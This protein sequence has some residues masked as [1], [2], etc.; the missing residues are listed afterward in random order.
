MSRYDRLEAV[1]GVGHPYL[2]E[3]QRMREYVLLVPFERFYEPVSV[4]EA[5]G[6][7]RRTVNLTP[8]MVNAWTRHVFCASRVRM[9]NL[10]D[11]VL[12]ELNAGRLLTA[13]VLMRSH[14]EA[15]AMACLCVHEIRKWTNTGDSASIE[16]LIPPTFF[17]TSMVRA[18]KKT[19]ALE[20]TLLFSEQDKVPIG[21]MISALDEFMSCGKP[22][23]RAHTIYGLLC[24]YTH[25]NMRALKDHTTTDN[26][27]V[28]GWFHRYRVNAELSKN[29]CIMAL[30]AL[31]TSMRAGHA[32]CEMLRRMKTGSDGSRGYLQPP[33]EDDLKEIWETFCRE[34][35]DV[36]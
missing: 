28:E 15:G 1:L 10:E 21:R 16:E 11:G 31:A 36:R 12:D 7:T 3:I 30:H 23:G 34:P 22:D 4:I 29:N 19:Q 13:M 18:E 5:A 9:L 14:V 27:S 17:G 26:D 24:E 8:E 2:T 35:E 32:A 25:P 6:K 33:D 20:G